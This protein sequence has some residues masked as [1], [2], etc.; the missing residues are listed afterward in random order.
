MEY[1][2]NWCSDTSSRGS[3]KAGGI[4]PWKSFE[5]LSLKQGRNQKQRLMRP[6]H[7]TVPYPKLSRTVHY[8]QQILVR[9][10]AC[11]T[12]QQVAPC[13]FFYYL[14]RCMPVNICRYTAKVPQICMNVSVKLNVVVELEC[15]TV[16]PFPARRCLTLCYPPQRNKDVVVLVRCSQQLIRE[17]LRLERTN[18]IAIGS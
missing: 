6:T 2:E 1:R 9:L 3:L 10:G 4:L 7:H 13:S 5:R 11:L 17:G 16:V 18:T 8:S 14:G 15:V 12:R